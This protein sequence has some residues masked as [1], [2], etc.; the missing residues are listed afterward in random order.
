MSVSVTNLIGDLVVTSNSQSGVSMSVG[1]EFSW[2][3]SAPTGYVVIGGGATVD[4]RTCHLVESYP[5]SFNG[6]GLPTVW[7]ARW[8]LGGSGPDSPSFT[9]WAICARVATF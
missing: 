9:V 4:R 2:G 8:Q 6:A 3:V 7:N 5:A 1:D